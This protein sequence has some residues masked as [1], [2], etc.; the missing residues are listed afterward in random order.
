MGGSEHILATAGPISTSIDGIK[1]FMKA[2]LDASPHLIEPSLCPIPWREES[3]LRANGSPKRLKVGVLWHD[4]VIRPHPPVT[5]ALREVV[6]KL[7]TSPDFEVVDWKP[8]RHD[9]AWKILVSPTS[10]YVFILL[11]AMRGDQVVFLRWGPGD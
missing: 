1:L 2:I 3:Q 5:R 7:R 10:A 9:W 4:G 8:H 6:E 11:M